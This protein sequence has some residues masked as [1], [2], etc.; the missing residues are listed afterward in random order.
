MTTNKTLVMVNSNPITKKDILSA[1]DQ[2]IITLHDSGNV[3]RVMSV[4]NG[5][6]D[7]EAVSG[8]ARAKLLYATSEWYKQEEPDKS[9]ID[10]VTSFTS[11]NKT[12]VDRYITVQK[13]IENHD[14]PKEIQDRPMRDLI[15]I[16]KT[17][18][19]GYD[20]SKEQWRK[21]KNTT[22]DGELR[23]VLRQVKGKAERKSAKVLKLDRDGSLYLYV[24]GQPKKFIGYLNVDDAENDTAIAEEIEKIKI[25]CG[26]IE[27]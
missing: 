9:F 8:H 16:A 4:L 6:S 10:D 22:N 3:Q 7:I 2:E 5:L 20:I 25:K 27:E 14:I 24:K 12:V 21:I 13:F 23:D 17:L 15:P 18:A 26:I 11:M 1:I 19:Q